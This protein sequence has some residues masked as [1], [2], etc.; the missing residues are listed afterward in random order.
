MPSYTTTQLLATIKNKALIPT[1]QVTFTN[2]NI[3]IIANEEMQTAIVPMIMAVREEFFVTYKDFTISD[4]G[5]AAG[6]RIPTRAVGTKLRDLTYVNGTQ[7]VQIPLM[8]ED[9]VNNQGSGYQTFNQFVAFIRAN[10]IFLK[11]AT[12]LAGTLRQYFFLRSSDLVETNAVGRIDS[13]DTVLKQVV[14]GNVPSTFTINTSYDFVM[15]NPGF[16]IL[17]QDITPT[18]VASS[19]FTFTDLPVDLAVGDYLCLAGESPVPMIPVEYIPVLAQRVIVRILEAL[20][21]LNG[22]S[23]ARAKL[24]ELE[25]YAQGLI[26]PRVEGEPKKIINNFSPLNLG[27]RFNRFFGP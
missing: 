9:E 4:L 22:V 10:K 2:P 11:P 21:D 12:G 19:T 26:S 6:Y 27:R 5:T 24:E 3:L 18:G 20:G 16:D 8:P 25:K 23:T 17:T 1:N 13:I 14:L 7:E 15:A